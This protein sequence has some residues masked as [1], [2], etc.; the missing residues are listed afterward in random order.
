MINPSGLNWTVHFQATV[1]WQQS[2]NKSIG[3]F[4]W[5]LPFFP[6][7]YATAVLYHNPPIQVSMNTDTNNRLVCNV[8]EA[9]SWPRLQC[10]PD[11]VKG[12]TF[13]PR[14]YYSITAWFT[15]A[16]TPA[17]PTNALVNLI[18]SVPLT[19]PPTT[20]TL[21][22]LSRQAKPASPSNPP[23][24]CGWSSFPSF[25]EGGMFCWVPEQ[26]LSA[27]DGGSWGWNVTDL[28]WSPPPPDR[29]CVVMGCYVPDLSLWSPVG[30]THIRLNSI[31]NKNLYLVSF[32][33]DGNSL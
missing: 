10:H 18:T 9:S 11:T 5:C 22:S 28:C 20:T 25:K 19:P 2:Q 17:G 6:H 23:G 31:C 14:H 33:E 29:T 30:C 26:Q 1:K 15:G 21:L 27:Q 32:N 16:S 24:P 4:S 13:S 8:A 12:A 3:K 7:P